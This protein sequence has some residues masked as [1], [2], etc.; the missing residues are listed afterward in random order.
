MTSTNQNNKSARKKLFFQR[1]GSFAIGYF[2]YALVM[3]ALFFLLFRIRSDV[4]LLA[5]QAGKNLVDV[6]GISNIIVVAAGVIMLV[7]VVYSEDYLRKGIFD[8]KL[9]KC[10]LRIALATGIAWGGWLVLFYLLYWIIR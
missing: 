3:A 2:L 4:I 6:R 7:G 10:I 5:F 8:G 1:A 9:W